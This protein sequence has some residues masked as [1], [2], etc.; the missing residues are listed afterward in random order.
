MILSLALKRAAII[1][2]LFAP[3]N[4]VAESLA[5]DPSSIQNKVTNK[6]GKDAK[7]WVDKSGKELQ[8][9]AKEIYT[10]NSSVK[11]LLKMKITQNGH[12]F[13]SLV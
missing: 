7:P 11:K 13:V 12:G 8:S 1:T 9:W 6:A 2:G 5:E 3:L 4:L 10:V